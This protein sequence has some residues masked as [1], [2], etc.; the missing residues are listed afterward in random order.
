MATLGKIYTSCTFLFY[1]CFG[2]LGRHVVRN[3]GEKTRVKELKASR[4][5]MNGTYFYRSL[6]ER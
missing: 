3:R 2:A 1:F 6:I 5:T 4:G